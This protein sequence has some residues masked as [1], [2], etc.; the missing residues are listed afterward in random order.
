MTRPVRSALFAGLAPVL[1]GGCYQYSGYPLDRPVPAMAVQLTLNDRGRVALENNIGPEIMTVD[2]T[3]ASVTDSTFVLRVTRVTSF[4]RRSQPWA[5]EPVTFRTEH[6]RMIRERRFSVGRT[7]LF[8]GSV[9]A[10]AAAFAA[11]GILIGNAL[12]ER[13]DPTGPGGGPVDN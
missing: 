2:G 9:A 1:A 5:G 4:D 7:V 10:S 3:V 6:V 8:A 11:T 12:G 13:S